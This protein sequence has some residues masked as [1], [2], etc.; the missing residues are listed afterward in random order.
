VGSSST[1][2]E[3]LLSLKVAGPFFMLFMLVTGL[4]YLGIAT[5]VESSAMG[6]FGAFVLTLFSGKMDRRSFYRAIRNTCVTSSMIGLVIVC[7]QLF[8]TFL[9]MTQ[10]TQNLVGFVSQIGWS[11]LTILIIILL[12]YLVLGCFLDQLSILIL[13]IP[14]VLPVI[15]SLGFDPI[16]FG[17]IVILLAEIGVVTPP[18]GLNVFVVSRVTNTPVEEVF[19]GVYPHVI[20]HILAVI[21]MVA[22]P[23][24]IT[25]LPSKM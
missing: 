21:L 8:G 18:V 17:I 19:R 9:T 23:A 5:P 12:V 14:I 20:A 25:W 6:A 3:K 13:T 15:K 16:W 4:I 10:A 11:P 7:A 22:F 24:I 2:K 1:W